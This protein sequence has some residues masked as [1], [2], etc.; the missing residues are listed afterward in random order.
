[1]DNDEEVKRAILKSI[2]CFKRSLQGGSGIWNG[3]LTQPADTMLRSLTQ[4]ADTT[5][6]TDGRSHNTFTF[7]RKDCMKTLVV[8][9]GCA[10]IG[11]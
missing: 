9:Q 1:M 5:L 4:P 10:I 2:Y 6:R 3:S 11:T 7:V 8:H